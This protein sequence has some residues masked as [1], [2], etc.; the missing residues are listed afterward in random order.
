VD[1]YH[2][3]F[4]IIESELGNNGFGSIGGVGFT[5][6]ESFREFM[7]DLWGLLKGKPYNLSPTDKTPAFTKGSVVPY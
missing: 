3:Q 2:V 6:R 7:P 1:A 4:D 5:S